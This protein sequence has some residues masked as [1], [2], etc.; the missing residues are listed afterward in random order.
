VN[1]AFSTPSGAFSATALTGNNSRAS[2][3]NVPEGSVTVSGQRGNLAG[4]RTVGVRGKNQNVELTLRAPAGTAPPLPGTTSP[5]Q[6]PAVSLRINNGA[7]CVTRDN[8]I[9][10]NSVSGPAPKNYRASEDRAALRTAP[11]Q[12]YNA[13][14]PFRLGAGAGTKT[15]Y[16][17]VQSIESGQELVSEIASDTINRVAPKANATLAIN[18]GAGTT[19]DRK[20]TLNNTASFD[21]DGSN[22]KYI[23][24]ED[25]DFKGATWQP[26]S[27]APQFTLSAGAGTKTVYFMATKE[28]CGTVVGSRPVSDTIT[29][30]EITAV[31]PVV[32][33]AEPTITTHT[34]NWNT[35]VKPA[36]VV[37]YAQGQGFTF[38]ASRSGGDGSCTRQ[39][40]RLT[41]TPTSGS[42]VGFTRYDDLKCTFRMFGGRTLNSGW[43]TGN[44]SVKTANQYPSGYAAPILTPWLVGTDN[45]ALTVIW[46]LPELTFGPLLQ[47]PAPG[48]PS[49]GAATAIIEELV[50]KGPSTDWRDAFRH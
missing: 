10:N 26:Y 14:P 44:L 7:A 24:S 49:N 40:A 47:A 16:M 12:L 33:V 32:S 43:K 5:P 45:P 34:F 22:P 1:S 48:F 18:N 37:S 8:V 50:I 41:A 21:P 39:D 29:L 46:V 4:E 31:E 6:P 2:F 35:A 13:A 36:D 38:T 42:G 23:A 9:L 28:V 3:K 20:V 15:V 27:S 19:F 25:K 11:W 30:G 17:Q